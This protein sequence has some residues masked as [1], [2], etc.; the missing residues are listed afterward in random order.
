MFVLSP[1][2]VGGGGAGM[3]CVLILVG[4]PAGS[5]SPVHSERETEHSERET[6]HSERETAHFKET[7]FSGNFLPW[8]SAICVFLQHSICY[9]TV[10]ASPSVVMVGGDPLHLLKVL[11]VNKQL[12]SSDFTLRKK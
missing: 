2:H 5:S 11:C 7:I 9:R 4:K 10:A 6:E 1:A 3:Y 8:S 12:A